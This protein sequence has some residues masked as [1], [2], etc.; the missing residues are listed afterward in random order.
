MFKNGSIYRP[1]APRRKH[2]DIPHGK[3]LLFQVDRNC[4]VPSLAAFALKLETYLRMANIPYENDYSFT[5]S[6][7]GKVPW[8]IVNDKE[9]ADSSFCIEHLSKEFSVDLDRE[10]SSEKKALAQLLTK[11]MEENTFWATI[12][13]TR[14][15]D[16]KEEWLDM[17]DVRPNW[18]SF[19]KNQGPQIVSE[20]MYGHGIG[21]HSTE[22]IHHIGK[23]DLRAFSVILGSKDYFLADTPTTVDACMFGCLANILYATP[24][25]GYCHQLL[26]T[27]L[28]NLVD[29][30]ERMKEKFW[31][32][33]EEIT[34][35]AP[36]GSRGD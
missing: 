14:I 5:M 27:E 7:K 9:V 4:L 8:I 16:A 18:R 24:K 10:L 31:P 23:Q 26:T 22:E 33:W 25:S 32:D 1:T 6:S 13:Q 17:I 29:Y 3:V 36:R 11:T 21:R 19:F 15:F 20:Y 12:E 34:A 30:V 28:T 2:Y 35:A